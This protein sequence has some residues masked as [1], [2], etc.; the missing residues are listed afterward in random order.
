MLTLVAGAGRLP[1]RV[2]A[3][4]RGSGVKIYALEDVPLIADLAVEARRFRLEHLA[5]VLEEMRTIGGRDICFAGSVARPQIDPSQVDA[6]TGPMME[7]ILAALSQGD[8]A[9]LRVLLG[10]FE[11]AGMR[12]LG[13]HEVVPEL[14]MA[15]GVPTV[16]RPD[17][18]DGVNAARAAAIVRA[19]GQV[20]VGQACIVADGQALAVE[21]LP[22]TNWM[23]ASLGAGMAPAPSATAPTQSALQG[24][25][26][27]AL[28][29]KAPKPDQDRRV[30]LPTIGLDTVEQAAGLGLRGLVIAAGE[31]IVLDQEDV[32]AA[33]DRAG[34][35]LWVRKPAP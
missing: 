20:D 17:H 14:V 32:I 9:A 31:V 24:L 7:Q 12:V 5:T 4:A 19:L 6:A 26:P 35:F 22:G 27:R 30:D 28:L 34:L 8:D 18:R 21:A 11:K 29:Y 3:S 16:A 10:F 33:C 2:V 23:L 1:E 25:L 13:A 15:E